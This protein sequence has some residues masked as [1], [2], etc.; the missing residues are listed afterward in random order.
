MALSGCH[1]ST[2]MHLEHFM[3][4]H[5]T[6]PGEAGPL[7][8]ER[9]ARGGSVLAQGHTAVKRESP[10]SSPEPTHSPKTHQGALPGIRKNSTWTHT[11]AFYGRAGIMSTLQKGGQTGWDSGSFDGQASVHPDSASPLAG[12]FAEAP[13]LGW[14]LPQGS[15]SLGLP[16][17]AVLLPT[18][19]CPSLPLD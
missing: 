8:Q 10:F 6:E 15:P 14:K 13:R 5:L 16:I 2:S 18:I 3:H 4:T 19:T 11:G 1:D 17:R 7:L 9:E 12:S